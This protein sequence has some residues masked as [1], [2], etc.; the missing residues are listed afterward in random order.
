M[1]EPRIARSSPQGSRGA[2]RLSGTASSTFSRLVQAARTQP[3]LGCG[4][5]LAHVPAATQATGR[6]QKLKTMF[7]AW[8]G[9]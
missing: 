5:L 3:G 1:L 8:D 2:R 9:Y 4:G 6:H 7:Q